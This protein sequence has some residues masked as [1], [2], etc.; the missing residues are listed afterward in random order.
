M[1]VSYQ[2]ETPRQSRAVQLIKIQFQF[3]FRPLTIMKYS[4]QDKTNIACHSAPFPAVLFCSS[5][6]GQF[7]VQI[8]K[9]M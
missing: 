7:Q 4:N 3:Q 2:A 6:K 9:I 5:L 8:S 1:A